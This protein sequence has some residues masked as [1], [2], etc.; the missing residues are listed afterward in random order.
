[1]TDAVSPGDLWPL[2]ASVSEGPGGP[3]SA[4]PRPG[5]RRPGAPDGVK[6]ALFSAAAEAVELCLFDKR[7]A[8]RRLPLRQTQQIWHG[9]VPGIGAG[10]QYG[11]RVHGPWRPEEGHRFNPAKLLADP[12][13]RA[14]AGEMI[15]HD[16]IYGGGPGS[17]RPDH[18]DS[19][20]YV[21]R[22]VV[23]APAAEPLP[24]GPRVPWADTVIYELH[25]RG[26]TKQHPDIPAPLR[27]TYAGLAHPAAIEHLIKLGVT[28]VELMPVCH[29][30][31][32]PAVA[33][34]GLSNY[35]GYNSLGYFAPDARL[36]SSADPRA[37]FLAMTRALH[38]AG[39][40][41]ILD[42]VYNHTGEGNHLGPTL[43]FRGVDNA[44]YYRLVPDDRRYYMDF[45]GCGN[46]LNMTHPRT[47][48]LIMDS[49]RYW[50]L[51]MHVDGFRFDLASTLA[52]ELHEVDRLGAF[53]DIIH[54]D[55]V[56]SQVKLI[57]EPWDV[58][59]GGYQVGNFPNHWAEWNGVYR[60][61]VRAYWKGDEGQAAGLAYRLT[62]SSDLYGRG[63][64]RPYA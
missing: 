22:S 53:F 34:R 19:A 6:F 49:L 44:S 52:R 31:T 60:D 12:Y 47:L 37:E 62:G 33:A 54:Q 35:W 58:G 11:Y 26:F 10:Q 59:E 21:P 13:A 36:S 41:V 30:V 43:C 14:Y 3:S 15:Y 20:P 48:Q 7:G 63:G 2:G 45:T 56:I 4:T 64:R 57:A 8:E 24:P 29:R 51:E 55:P 25:V 38:Q 42:V 39:I 46:S 16:A 50:I 18:R 40:E 32:E 9:F 5:G 17:G 27:G 28:A 1:M 61:T 23:A